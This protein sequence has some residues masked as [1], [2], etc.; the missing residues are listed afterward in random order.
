MKITFL[1]AAKTVTGSCYLIE[2]GKSRFL[3]DCGMFQGNSKEIMLNQEP[4]PINP[5]D[6]DYILL[7][8][9][10]IDHSGRIPKIYRDGFRGEIIS[11]RATAQ[12]CGIMLPDSGYIQ[13]SEA[14]WVNR[15]RARAGKH[16]VEPLYTFQDAINCLSLFR[17]V[18]YGQVLE[19]KDGIRVRFSNAGHILGSSILEIWAPDNGREVKTVFSGDL[20]NKGIPI[21]KDPDTVDSADYLIIES[22]YADKVHKKVKDETARF[23]DILNETIDRG[24]NV[25]I[26]S[27][28]V[29]RTQE[30]IYELNKHKERYSSKTE[31]IYSTPV[32]VDS[33]LAISATE[34]FR[35]NLECFD[36]EAMAYVRNGDNPLDFPGLKFSRTAEESKALNNDKGSK[37]II[38]ASGMC[39]AGRI[40]H[41]LKHNLWRPESTVLFVG[42]QAEGT[43]GRRLVDGAKKVRIFGEEINVR[44]RIEIIEGFS[45]HADRE[46]LFEWI[47]AFKKKPSKIYIVHGEEPAMSGFAASIG[48]KYGI[49]AYVPG[50]GATCDLKVGYSQ[51]KEHVG[52]TKIGYRKL[53][54]T[55][56]LEKLK[57]Q[58]DE[59]GEAVKGRFAVADNGMETDDSSNMYADIVLEK[60]KGLEK[61]I[62]GIK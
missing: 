41:H 43:L 5:A 29:G 7:T 55:E 49:E 48:S 27:F 47:D 44:A 34:I 53:A 31:K 62:G 28:A 10:H 1:G 40:K 26:P 4:F 24:G 22:T 30:V 14:D 20:G 51:E 52:K 50:R 9:A 19:L 59:A 37:I 3:V 18:V 33:P 60:L 11:T 36:E 56:M 21:M 17:H 32:F 12:L 35:N 23:V 58:L 16:P 15:K 54:V 8:H 46:G 2:T 57:D 39:E 6:V 38:S 61:V 45:G 13:E 42:F 25:V